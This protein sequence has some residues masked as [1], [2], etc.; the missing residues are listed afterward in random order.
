MNEEDLRS[1]RTRFG[2]PDLGRGD[3][4]GAVLSA[5]RRQPG[6]AVP[7][8]AAQGA[9]WLRAVAQR[10][11]S[12]RSTPRSTRS[13][14]SST[15]APATARPRRR[16]CSC[17]CCRSCCATRRS[18]NLIVPIVPDEARTFG[19]ES[20]FRAVGIYSHVGQRYEPVD[21]DTLLYYKEATDGQILEEGITEA[22]SM[23][24]F[25]AAGTAYATYGVNTIP[26]FI[27]YSMFGFQ[28]VADLIWAGADSR[29][30]GL[31]A[32]CD[33]RPHDP[34][35]RRAAAPGRPQP[36]LLAR[37]I[38]NCM[39]YDP[40]Y[41]YELAV[42]IQDGIRRMYRDQESIF[43]YLTR[44]ERAVRDAGDAGRG[45]RRHPQGHVSLQQGRQRQSQ[46]ES[47]APRQRNDPQRGARPRPS[48]SRSTVLRPTSGA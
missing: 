26:F 8:R 27:F 9:R 41:A 44:D 35:G 19:M 4:R 31:P 48:C 46:A 13:S 37:P 10:C 36:R 16:W 23:S 24:S 34:G 47:A 11:R 20:L 18:A 7:A 25:I 38:P 42:I 6:A 40:A 22:G 15:R 32:R 12:S 21:M 14:R 1:F 2:I 33:R 43:Y 17:G 30:R 39:S 45:P 3:C 29:M 5:G 28:R